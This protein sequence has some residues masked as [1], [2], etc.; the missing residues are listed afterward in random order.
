MLGFLFPD[1]ATEVIV[2]L[3]IRASTLLQNVTVNGHLNQSGIHFETQ[4]DVTLV[5][6]CIQ[7]NSTWQ[8]KTKT[9]KSRSSRQNSEPGIFSVGSPSEGTNSSS[10]HTH[11]TRCLF[12][13]KDIQ[14]TSSKTGEI[15]E[16][17]STLITSA[18]QF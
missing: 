14:R 8:T 3:Q 11:R 2:T 1:A 6:C 13:F 12:H 4:H 16:D 18:L 7:N 17:L 10:N 9:P 15:L 5:G